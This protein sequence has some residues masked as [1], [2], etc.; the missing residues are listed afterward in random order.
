MPFRTRPPGTL[1]PLRRLARRCAGAWALAISALLPGVASAQPAVGTTLPSGWTPVLSAHSASFELSSRYTGQRYRIMIA[2]PHQPAPAAGYPVLW[3][4][5]GNATFP[6]LEFA[7]PRLPTPGENPRWRRKVGIEP[8]GLIVAV[9]HMSG[10]PMD[11]DARA[12]D[13]TPATSAPAGDQLSARHG[14][15][16]AF[17]RFLTEELRPLLAAHFPMDPQRHTLFGFSYGGL[18]ALN[19]LATAPQHFQRYWAA[20]PSLWFGQGEVLRTLPSRLPAL[21]E[22]ATPLRLML[23]VGLEE[24]HPAQTLPPERL[25]MLQQRAMVDNAREYVRLLQEG[26]GAAVQVRHLE[27]AA[28]DHRDMLFHGARRVVDFAFAP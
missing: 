2:L 7:R 9:G 27:L 13:Y 23:T 24:Q 8:A 1:H 14:G 11:V 3:A 17:L 10:E 4:L 26:A 25:Q 20:S 18:F 15:A 12:Q 21:R 28:H 16:Q 19:T 5:D 22:A 6:L